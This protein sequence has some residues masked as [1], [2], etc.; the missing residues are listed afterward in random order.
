M[1]QNFTFAKAAL[2]SALLV[3]G[4]TQLNAKGGDVAAGIAIGAAAGAVLAAAASAANA[5]WDS[6]YYD[7]SW[8]YDKSQ[9]AIAACMHKAGKVASKRGAYRIIAEKL[10]YL[11]NRGGGQFKVGLRMKAIY[12]SGVTVHYA[13]CTVQ[14]GWISAFK[15]N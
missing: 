6:D 12:R 2:A 3:F 15:M 13:K 8:N 7:Y 11:N 5:D 9:N 4:A 10:D 1:K 14:N